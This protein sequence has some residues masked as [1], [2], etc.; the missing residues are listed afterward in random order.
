VVWYFLIRHSY[1]FCYLFFFSIRIGQCDLNLIPLVSR[2]YFDVFFGARYLVRICSVRQCTDFGSFYTFVF[3]WGGGSF[4]QVPL[5]D[6]FIAPL[7]FTPYLLGQL[8]FPAVSVHETFSTISIWIF[9]YLHSLL[10]VISEF[11]FSR[12]A[13]DSAMAEPPSGERDISWPPPH[14][15][16][17]RRVVMVLLSTLRWSQNERICL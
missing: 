5:T 1:G 12:W 11:A 16:K 10:Y 6:L 9:D 4:S 17:L 3:F 2:L 7:V 14:T 15:L 13:R 8:R